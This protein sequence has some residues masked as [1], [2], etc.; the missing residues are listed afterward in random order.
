MVPGGKLAGPGAHPASDL[1]GVADKE[2]EWNDE[3]NQE[4]TRRAREQLAKPAVGP[5]DEGERLA[6]ARSAVLRAARG[7]G[8][9]CAIRSAAITVSNL[10]GRSTAASPTS[11]A[12]IRGRWAP[13]SAA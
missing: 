13:L 8:R 10:S 3:P 5:N 11:A 2:Q 7:C 12:T 6:E 1:H 4:K 9:P